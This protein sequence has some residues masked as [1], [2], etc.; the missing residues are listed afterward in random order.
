M[1]L[2]MIY[3]VSPP[4]AQPYWR[5]AIRFNFAPIASLKA[6]RQICSH[7]RKVLP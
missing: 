2:N 5:N 6:L 7:A 3:L 1:P 4:Q